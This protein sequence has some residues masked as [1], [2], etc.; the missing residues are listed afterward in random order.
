M[1]KTIRDL[2]YTPRYARKGVMGER[3]RN[4]N[5]PILLGVRL[6]SQD[7]VP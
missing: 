6:G 4:L 1:R 5:S 3:W 7:P 2:E